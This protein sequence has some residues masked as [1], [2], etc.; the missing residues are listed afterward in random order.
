MITWCKKLSFAR[1]STQGLVAVILRIIGLITFAGTQL[2]IIQRLPNEKI[3]YSALAFAIAQYGAL[4]ITLGNNILILK[5]WRS[6]ESAGEFISE[7]F[8]YRCFTLL[9]VIG[10]SW[11]VALKI[12]DTFAFIV[13]V[14]L[15]ISNA[16]NPQWVYQCEARE[17]NYYRDY[18]LVCLSQLF[19]VYIFLGPD[20]PKGF[21][22]FLI[23][24]PAAIFG[25]WISY[26]F[27]TA[28]APAL[29]RLPLDSYKK[30]FH[31]S[32]YL[33]FT[34]IITTLYLNILYPILGIVGNLT[35]VSEFRVVS[36]FSEVCASILSIIPVLLTRKVIDIIDTGIKCKKYIN[37]IELYLL[38]IGGFTS[39]IVYMLYPV[40][41]EQFLSGK[42]STGS[43]AAAMMTMSRF[44]AC[45]SAINIV[46]LV[47]KRREYK[48]L[49]ISLSA[50]VLGLCLNLT[51]TYYLK[52]TGA[53]LSVFI[54]ELIVASLIRTQARK[55]FNE[56]F[57]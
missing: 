45:I 24:L 50:L 21:D 51:L 31:D 4:F 3:G 54:L 56:Y 19:L 27:I 2:I 32:K 37:T 9:L 13:I 34:A 40:L 14:T 20:L 35:I 5:R 36:Y 11:L 49:K 15:V 12:E 6:Q 16:G 29:T 17:Q 25:V 26:K 47:A 39:V 44:I 38:C 48:I 46:I 22:Q 42:F 18:L 8:T 7:V 53:A 33:F 30:V 55:V 41:S 52:A 1:F 43:F 28:N 23:S 10:L 57:S